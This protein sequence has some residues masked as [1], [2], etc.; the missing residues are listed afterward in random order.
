MTS[1]KRDPVLIV[2][3]LTGGNDYMNTVVP[4][5]DPL[6]RE[7]RP[8]VGVAEEDVLDIDGHYGF[9]PVLAPLK[10]LYDEGRVAVVN[11]IGYPNPNRSHFRAMD[12]WHTC[13]P[14]RVA[15]RGLAGPGHPRPGSAGR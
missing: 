13:E 9:N 5:G 15:H 10:E 8:T 6:Y 7:N 12:I 14:E 3:Q 1:T 11:G 2:V 4:Y